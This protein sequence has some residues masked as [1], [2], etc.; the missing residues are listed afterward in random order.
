MNTNIICLAVDIAHIMTKVIG[1]KRKGIIFCSTIDEANELGSKFTGNCVSHSKLPINVKAEN[2]AQWKSED[3]HWIAA[4]TGMI[5]GIDEPNVGAVIFVGI[6]Y[7]LVNVYQGAGR[8]GRD[9][10]PSWAIILQSSNTTLV[11]PRGGLKEDPQ[12]LQEGQ[13][14]LS[15]EQCRRIGFSQLFDNVN[16]S[17]F[18][19]LD[20]HFCDFCNPDMEL[21]A[22]LRSK[23]VDPL[24]L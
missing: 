15:I 19:L 3:G 20:A 24:V 10:T 2:E 4:T 23:I 12:C 7:G 21:L 11:L 6:G 9:G 13:D 17:C 14:W 1:L 5:C 16:V 18:N 8:T 22:D